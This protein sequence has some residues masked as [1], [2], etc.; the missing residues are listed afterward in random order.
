[1]A[2][3]TFQS[4]GSVREVKVTGADGAKQHCVE[5]ALSAAVVPPF[6]EPTF[7]APV[8]VRSLGR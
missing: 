4:D 7:S 6:A 3:V 1:M 2:T 5:A 8:T